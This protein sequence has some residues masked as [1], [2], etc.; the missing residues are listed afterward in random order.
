MILL[1][2]KTII[3]LFDSLRNNFEICA[4]LVKINNEYEI[5]EYTEGKEIS[6]NP[7]IKSRGICTWEHWEKSPTPVII[8][9]HPELSKSYP[10]I[11]DYSKAYKDK[12]VDRIKSSLIFT[13]VGLFQIDN[14]KYGSNY[15]NTVND[16]DNIDKFIKF[17][18]KRFYDAYIE[19]TKSGNTKELQ[20]KY[21]IITKS[22][23][24]QP[25][26]EIYFF[27]F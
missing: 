2:K 26:F 6:H 11:E 25:R 7:L 16:I 24:K 3:F 23:N 18:D 21:N 5:Q 8:H 20:D 12:Y 13:Q 10:S 19:W 17:Y 9:T 22:I 4:T 27:P 1:S 15:K 14:T